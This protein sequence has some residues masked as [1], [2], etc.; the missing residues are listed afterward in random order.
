[1]A[2]NTK[3]ILITTVTAMLQNA[4]LDRITVRALCE[5]SNINGK[6]FYYNYSDKYQLA[7][8]AIF[9]D[10][11][12]LM[13]GKFESHNWKEGMLDFL[14]YLQENRIM[15]AHIEQSSYGKQFNEDFE[16]FTIGQYE[17][18]ARSLIN[19][20]CDTDRQ[21]QQTSSALIRHIARFYAIT[22]LATIKNWFSCG[23]VGDPQDLV[24]YMD[25]MYDHA[26]TNSFDNL[27]KAKLTGLALTV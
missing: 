21:G 15:L 26:I 19:E 16:K 3:T 14:D 6:T 10:L 18:F 13:E 12:R 9:H 2:R 17:G 4:N 5:A 25:V 24:A 1:M 23:P 20:Q 22:V 11:A 8:D 27:C 7:H